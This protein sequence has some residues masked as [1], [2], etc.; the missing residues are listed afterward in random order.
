MFKKII[1]YIIG[2]LGF[3]AGFSVSIICKRLVNTDTLMNNWIELALQIFFA[4][5]IGLIS[6]LNSQIIIDKWRKPIK[7]LEDELEKI[8]LN[9][10][11]LG[12]F[13]IIIGLII[14]NLLSKPLEYIK[15]PYLSFILQVFLFVGLGYLGFITMTR[16]RGDIPFIG[17]D[18]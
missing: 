8:P 5:F 17:K 16:K 12:S 7:L 4:L 10:I 6:Y 2:F 13:G 15:I 11:V 14:A 3:A 18:I 9:E 1:N